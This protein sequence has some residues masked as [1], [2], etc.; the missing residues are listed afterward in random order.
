LPVV[1]IH[2]RIL[3]GPW[4][5]GFALDWHTLSSTYIGDNPFGHPMFDTKRPPVGQ[6]LFQLKY[7]NDHTAVDRLPTLLRTF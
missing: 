4:D 6:L 7:R 1:E 3:R 2:P 5:G